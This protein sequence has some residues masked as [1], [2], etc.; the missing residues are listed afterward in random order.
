MSMTCWAGFRALESSSPRQASRTRDTKPRTTAKLTSASSRA[1]R[2]SRRTSS[3]SSSPR[4][5][6][7]RRRGKIPP[8][9]SVSASNM[10]VATVSGR[11]LR[12][13]LAERARRAWRS[14]LGGDRAGG[15]ARCAL[16]PGLELGLQAGPHL[17]AGGGGAEQPDTHPQQEDD[18][19]VVAHHPGDEQDDLHGREEQPQEE[20]GRPP[21]RPRRP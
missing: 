12:P 16:R 13:A 20:H 4:R 19:A 17:R 1:R 5:P 10:R 9:R 3:T 18:E 15:G 6:L 14:D 7:P 21:Y 2:I 11:R 8:K